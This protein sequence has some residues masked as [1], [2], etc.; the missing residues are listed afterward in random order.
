MKSVLWACRCNGLGLV[1][2]PCTIKWLQAIVLTI[3]PA[4]PESMAS[5]DEL[6]INR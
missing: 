3:L 2:F 6:S 4:I 5:D 1:P